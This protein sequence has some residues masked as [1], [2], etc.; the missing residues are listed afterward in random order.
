MQESADSELPLCF[1]VS[2]G[3]NSDQEMIDF[4][5]SS[6]KVS[7]SNSDSTLLQKPGNSKWFSIVIAREGTKKEQTHFFFYFLN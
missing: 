2:L 3:D 4:V 1:L 5:R 6:A 7:L